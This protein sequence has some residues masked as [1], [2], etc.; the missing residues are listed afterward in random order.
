MDE[1]IQTDNRYKE[2]ICDLGFTLPLP[3]IW[4]FLILD[5]GLPNEAEFINHVHKVLS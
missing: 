2:A 3:E 5:W 4:I 1:G